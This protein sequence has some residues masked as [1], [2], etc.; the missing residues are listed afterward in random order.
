MLLHQAESEAP[1]IC[2]SF[3]RIIP[4]LVALRNPDVRV[5]RVACVRVHPVV[6]TV[7]IYRFARAFV[8]VYTCGAIAVCESVRECVGEL[9]GLCACTFT[10]RAVP[11]EHR[12]WRLRERTPDYRL[13]RL[14]PRGRAAF[15]P[16]LASFCTC[17]S[18]KT[19]AYVPPPCYRSS[20]SRPFSF[21]LFLLANGAQ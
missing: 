15:S 18:M 21:S 14:D 20:L 9:Q 5:P 16:L 6:A 1:A 3:D 8:C 4:D 7:C 12:Y 2:R 19:C 13:A 11:V 10:R 17:P